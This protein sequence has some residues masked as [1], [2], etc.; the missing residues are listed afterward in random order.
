MKKELKILIVGSLF[1]ALTYIF[2]LINVNLLPWSPG[3]GGLTHLGNIPVFIAAILFGKKTGAVVGGVGMALFD[4]FSPYAM[5]TP[6]T[7]VINLLMGFVIGLIMENRS[8]IKWYLTATGAAILIKVLGYYIAELI[9]IQMT[10][11][12]ATQGLW[13][14]PIASIPANVLQVV[15]A[16]IIVL[17]IIGRL[18]VV[19]ARFQER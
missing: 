11:S 1:I 6:F 12:A 13:L 7:F 8:K 4:L 14:I 18:R 16:A 9:I 10:S 3:G 2:T 17:P 5:W 19:A 15:A